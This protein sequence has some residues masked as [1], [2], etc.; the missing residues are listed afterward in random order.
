MTTKTVSV[1]CPGCNR[2]DK[3]EPLSGETWCRRCG[4][5]TSNLAPVTK[6]ATVVAP[7]VE[8]PVV[9]PKPKRSRKAKAPTITRD[10]HLIDLVT[11]PDCHLVLIALQNGQ[12]ET[13]GQ[14]L[15]LADSP[16]WLKQ[17]PNP[18]QRPYMVLR[19]MNGVSHVA[20]QIGDKLIDAGLIGGVK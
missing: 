10:T 4:G 9:E 8:A 13:V 3:T 19:R 18:T 16:F 11:G 6:P 5:Y 15:D 7:V 2:D 14:L 12:L 1:T 17:S 20:N